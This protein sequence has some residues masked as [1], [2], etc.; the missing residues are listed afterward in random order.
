MVL[1]KDQITIKLIITCLNEEGN[2]QDFIE[3]LMEYMPLKIN[4]SIVLVNNGSKDRT[5]SIIDGLAQKYPCITTIHRETPLDYGESILKA[6]KCPLN[7]IPDYIGWA[8]SDNQISGQDVAKT[9]KVLNFNKPAFLKVIRYEKNYSLWRK[10][11]SYSFNIIVSIL[12]K[13]NIKDING[14]PKFFRAELLPWLNLQG[15]GWFLDGEVHLKICHLMKK[16]DLAYVPVRFNEREHGKSKTSLIT[17][18][19]LFIQVLQLRLW[20]M[21]KWLK[22]L[23]VVKAFKTHTM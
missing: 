22:H 3:E 12:F 19:E 20:G 1:V 16:T 5:G 10:I 6:N 11:Q 2:V 15:K 14:S 9:I 17:A 13:R 8:P 21:P 23:H 4:I 7:F 18:F